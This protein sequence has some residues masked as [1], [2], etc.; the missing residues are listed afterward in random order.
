MPAHGV[1]VVFVEL[2]N[3]LDVV[4]LGPNCVGFANIVELMRKR[5]PGAKHTIDLTNGPGKLCAALGMRVE[6]SSG[7]EAALRSLAAVR[8]DAE[9]EQ[10]DR[11]DEDQHGEL[12]DIDI[13]RPDHLV[14]LRHAIGAAATA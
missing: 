10:R 1:T 5:R 14:E 11:N 2:A 6:T 13:A 8:A 4:F 3:E 9:R 7:V 12:A